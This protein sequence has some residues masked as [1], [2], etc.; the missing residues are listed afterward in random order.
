[1]GTEQELATRLRMRGA[2]PGFLFIYGSHLTVFKALCS[3]LPP[4][5]TW[6]TLCSGEERTQVGQVPGS[7]YPQCM[8]HPLSCPFFLNI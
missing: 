6:E 2:L 7:G 8:L 5:G 1:M 3:G 4:D